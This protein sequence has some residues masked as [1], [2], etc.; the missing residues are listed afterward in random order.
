METK[1]I[2]E[3]IS[4]AR[5]KSGLTQ[6]NLAEH[7]FI[8]PQAVGKWERGESVP[9][10]IMLNK[11]AKILEV[12]LNYFAENVQT[13]EVLPTIESKGN[14]TSILPVKT[15]PAWNMSMGNWVDAD[16]SGLKNLGEKFSSSNIQRCR[17]IGSEMAGILF[18]NNNIQQC[19]FSGSDFSGSQFQNSNL[20]KNNFSNAQLNQCNLQ[21]SMFSG[22]DFSGTDLS[23]VS[24]KSSGFEKCLFSGARLIGLSFTYTYFG[25]IIFEGDIQNCSFENCS[26]RKLTFQNT[27]LTNTFFKGNRLKR[28]KFVDCSADRLTYEFLKSGKADLSGITLI[29]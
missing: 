13:A 12:D 8:S 6:A 11:L 3:R 20:V 15:K 26:F 29:G 4:D 5:K 24:A 10:I 7:L 18:K 17:F 27:R 28:I 2:G 23:G 19:D 22:C 25:E 16:F 1:F 14:S 21:A 9:D